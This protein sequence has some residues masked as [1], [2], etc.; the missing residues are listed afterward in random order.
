VAIAEQINLAFTTEDLV[1]LAAKR[2]VCSAEELKSFN[3]TPGN[4]VKVIDFLLVGHAEHPIE[5][6]ALVQAGVFSNRPPQ[7]IANMSEHRYQALK[8]LLR[9][10]FEF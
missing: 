6:D 3:A 2:S 8:P 7:S 4:P 5:L 10:G 9:L 1:H